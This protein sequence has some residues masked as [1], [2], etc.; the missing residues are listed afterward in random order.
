MGVKIIVVSFLIFIL[1]FVV[2]SC[3]YFDNRQNYKP[4]NAST[5]VQLTVL[6]IK[7]ENGFI[8]NNQFYFGGDRFLQ[9][10]KDH[11]IWLKDELAKNRK[12]N[13]IIDEEDLLNVVIANISPPFD[14]YK[15]ANSNVMYLVK[16]NDSLKFKIYW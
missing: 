4:L 6:K 7:T 9:I 1:G 13:E 8:F 11:P 5:E 12:E 2:Y 10:G 16:N 14:L 3:N 15:K